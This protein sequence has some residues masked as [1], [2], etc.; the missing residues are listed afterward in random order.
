MGWPYHFLELTPAEQHERR[1]SLNRHSLYAQLSA[2]LPVIIFLLV[3][4]GRW[5]SRKAGNRVAY[6]AVPNSPAVKRERTTV[7]GTWSATIRLVAWWLG[8]EVRFAGQDWGR[9]DEVI[10]GTLWTIWLLFLCVIGTG[11]GRLRC[12]FFPHAPTNPPP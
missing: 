5:V 7:L 6:N 12:R 11:E 8:D 10:F 1:L 9:R 3:R 4:L 2:L